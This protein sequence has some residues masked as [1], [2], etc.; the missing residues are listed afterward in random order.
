MGVCGLIRDIREKKKQ[1]TAK[2]GVL[3]QKPGR[4]R[5]GKQ[6]TRATLNRVRKDTFILEPE[7]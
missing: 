1:K 6:W 4:E 2:V 3:G 5:D 7:E